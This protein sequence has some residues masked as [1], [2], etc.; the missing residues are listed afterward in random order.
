MVA[1]T[2]RYD[3]MAVFVEEPKMLPRVSLTEKGDI[4]MPY[5]AADGKQRC[6]LIGSE[7]NLNYIERSIIEVRAKLNQRRIDELNRQMQ[8]IS[9]P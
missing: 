1:S 3:P 2:K 4:R 7:E 5:V 6:L 8:G 9:V